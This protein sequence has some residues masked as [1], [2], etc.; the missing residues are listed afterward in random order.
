MTER[1]NCKNP[2]CSNSILTST[3][4]KNEGLCTPCVQAN[5]MREYQDYIS[6]N[7]KDVSLYHDVSDPVEIIK[8][9]GI[10]KL[11]NDEY[12]KALILNFRQ[13]EDLEQLHSKFP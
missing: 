3:A 7:R 4:E 9:M 2:D 11:T 13:Q 5:E 10:V 6:K 8:I 12:K 1:V